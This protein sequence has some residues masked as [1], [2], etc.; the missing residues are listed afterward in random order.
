MAKTA[1]R[2]LEVARRIYDIVTGEYGIPPGAL[3]FDALTFTL[4]TG[5]PEFAHSAV[6][7]IDGI[8]AI[9]A[10][11]PGVLTSL[12]VSNV[13]FG[14]KP[15]AARRAEL[16]DAPPLRRRRPRHGA[17]QRRRRSRPTASWTRPSANCATISC[18]TAPRRA[19]PAD[20]ALG[21]G[22]EPVARRGR[23][24]PTTTPTRRPRARIH[25]A[26]L[27]RR[28]DGIE[29]KI[30]EALLDARAGRR[31][32]RRPAAGDEGSRRQVWLGRADLAVRP[33]VGRGDEEGRRV[34]SNSSS[35]A[36]RRHQRKDRARDGFRRRARHRQEPR[37]H[38]PRPTTATRSTISANRF[39]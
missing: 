13:S 2:K 27:R 10:A 25:N 16:R 21:I 28:K 4:A 33:A 6:E 5:D 22:G 30:D 35:S 31:A 19:G 3:I 7:T 17:R 15:A 20:R 23:L 37:Q 36:R 1:E 11:L 29:A 38:D 24:R 32:Q 34:I 26:I 9:K 8:R 14:L 39:R 18:S 12:G